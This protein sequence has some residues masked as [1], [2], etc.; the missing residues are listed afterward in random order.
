MN[1]RQVLKRVGAG[2]LVT[3]GVGNA[4]AK[5]SGG[6]SVTDLDAV[7]VERGE[8]VVATL[9]NPSRSKVRRLHAEMDTDEELVTPNECCLKECRVDCAYCDYG[10]CDWMREC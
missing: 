9:E 1:R 3:L 5:Q 6:V 4:A 8:E 7:H 2:G 10:C